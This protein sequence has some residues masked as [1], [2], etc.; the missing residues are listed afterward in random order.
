MCR[1]DPTIH[2]S[3][4]GRKGCRTVVM[5]GRPYRGYVYIDAEAVR[6]KRQLDYWVQLALDYNGR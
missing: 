6:T 1:L 3:A 4:L 5:R 2:D